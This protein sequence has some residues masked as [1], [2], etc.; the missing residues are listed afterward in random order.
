MR[1]T[2]S[3]A[4]ST[5]SDGF[6]PAWL[7]LERLARVEVSSE[8]PAHP[9]EEALLGRASGWHAAASGPQTLRLC[10]DEPQ[11]LQRIRL[12]FEETQHERRQ[13]FALR[14]SADGTSFREIVRQQWN[15]SPSGSTREAE[16][17]VVVL[18]GVFVLE[19]H[20]IPDTSGGEARASLA[21]LRIA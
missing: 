13:E 16:N 12:H 3:P 8:D 2:I 19:L 17:Y 5:R 9:V 20:I 14:W 11:L 18:A 6:E 4:M 7:D 10:F 21:E 15:F 1:K